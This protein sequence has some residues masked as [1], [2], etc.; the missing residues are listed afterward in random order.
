MV[1]GNLPDFLHSVDPGNTDPL[2]L[3]VDQHLAGPAFPYAA[4][5][6]ALPVPQTVTV[7]GVTG[8]VKGCCDGKSMFPAYDLSFIGE[9]SSLG[10]GDIEDGMAGDLVHKV[11]LFSET[12]RQNYRKMR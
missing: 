5:Q 1:M 10:G 8:L 4:L 3:S 2:Y 6:A 7:D 11:A 9:S 12:R